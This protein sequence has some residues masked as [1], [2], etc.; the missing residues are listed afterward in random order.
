MAEPLKQVGLF[1]VGRSMAATEQQV[2]EWQATRTNITNVV[3]GALVPAVGLSPMTG[4]LGSAWNSEV[5]CRVSKSTVGETGKVGEIQV[6][7]VILAGNGCNRMAGWSGAQRFGWTYGK[8]G[9]YEA[10]SLLDDEAVTREDCVHEVGSVLDDEAVTCGDCAHEVDSVLCV[11]MAVTHGQLVV[12]DELRDI[13]GM[14]SVFSDMRHCLENGF[15]NRSSSCFQACCV[16]LP[17]EGGVSFM[18][19]NGSIQYVGIFIWQGET[20]KPCQCKD[21][22]WCSFLS[23]TDELGFCL[24][25]DGPGDSLV[26]AEK[27]KY[28]GT[29]ANLSD[30]IAT[31]VSEPD[32][33]K[34]AQDNGCAVLL[35]GRRCAVQTGIHGHERQSREHLRSTAASSGRLPVCRWRFS[36]QSGPSEK[37]DSD[38]GQD[39]NDHRPPSAGVENLSQSQSSRCP[40][41]HAYVPELFRHRTCGTICCSSCATLHTCSLEVPEVDA[42]SV[43]PPALTHVGE[44]TQQPL[45]MD[46]S[47]ATLAKQ[48]QDDPHF[49]AWYQSFEQMDSAELREY[50]A[51]QLHLTGSDVDSFRD[52]VRD[53]LHDHDVPD[54][55][56]QGQEALSET[57]GDSREVTGQDE[58]DADQYGDDAN[59]DYSGEGS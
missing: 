39:P 42:A 10:C 56:D 54:P 47:V 49:Y 1:D 21:F 17:C 40:V 33:T 15:G 38:Q 5:W 45:H 14:G 27:R 3:V 11:E 52:E 32:C 28:A 30:S 9:G 26:M 48:E 58:D 13:T 43:T 18:Y 50:A 19:S 25:A 55:D 8:P 53:Y 31:V 24:C 22:N 36:S 2:D 46:D 12:T 34:Y 23:I 4:D 7:Y 41:C 59:D 37:E 51:T 57:G 16:G 29:P 6:L 44:S 20:D 35:V